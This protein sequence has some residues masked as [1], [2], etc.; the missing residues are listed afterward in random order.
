MKRHIL[1]LPG[2]QNKKCHMA[3]SQAFTMPRAL[4]SPLSPLPANGQVEV[5]RRVI[6]GLLPRQ[7]LLVLTPSGAVGNGCYLRSPFP[8]SHRGS[9]GPWGHPR[10]QLTPSA[11]A[12]CPLAP[13]QFS[14]EVVYS[15]SAIKPELFLL[16]GSCSCPQL[17]EVVGGGGQGRITE[18]AGGC[19]GDQ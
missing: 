3:W 18:G 17:G 8:G 2:R 12:P 9:P 1:S 4:L 16:A 15:G 11:R 10:W 7:H 13:V 5:G 14:I 19:R 6:V